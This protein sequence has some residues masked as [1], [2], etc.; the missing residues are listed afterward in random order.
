MVAHA[1]LEYPVKI[2]FDT[3][4][5]ATRQV[6]AETGLET[7]LLA[8]VPAPPAIFR[9]E[10]H[11]GTPHPPKRACLRRPRGR[12]RQLP[13]PSLVRR[14]VVSAMRLATL[15]DSEKAYSST[16]SRE[17]VLVHHLQTQFSFVA[18]TAGRDNIRRRQRHLPRA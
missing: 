12:T 4:A 5:N 14:T 2:S 13:L 17:D 1:N 8:R 16:V 15:G 11:P 3:A 18:Y 9:L 7:Y 10:D 6:P